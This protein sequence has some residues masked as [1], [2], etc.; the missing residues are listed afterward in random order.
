MP[1]GPMPTSA[2]ATKDV[3]KADPSSESTPETETVSAEAAL[4]DEVEES[5]L[6]ILAESKNVPYTRFKEVN[7]GKKALEKQLADF[8]TRH[9]REMQRAIDDAETRMSTRFKKEQESR[10]SSDDEN[11]DPWEKSTRVA[12]RRVEQA[13]EKLAALTARTAQKDLEHELQTLQAKYPEADRLAVMGWAT[14]VKDRSLEELMAQ[15]H[16]RN[17]TKVEERLRGLLEEKK[18]RAKAMIPTRE[19]G[20]RLKESDRPKTLKDAASAARKYFQKIGQG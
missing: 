16:E 19:G 5:D 2:P 12:L 11:L 9:Q 7:E 4:E 14:R 15:S 18:K 13:E 17:L 10:A 6:E 8:E 3:K 20:I 1:A